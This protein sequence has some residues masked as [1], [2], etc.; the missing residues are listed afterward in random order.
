MSR[1]HPSRPA[2]ALLSATLLLAI[3]APPTGAA[4]AP[5]RPA[6]RD[7]IALGSTVVVSWNDLGMHCMNQNH[8]NMSILPPYNNLFAQ[9]IQR[10][11]ETHP[12]RLLTAGVTVE[13]SVPGNTYSVGKTD[14][15]TYA[16]ALFGV[17]LPPNVG[18]T[19]KGL[20]GS[21]DLSGTAFSAHGIPVSPWPDN[22]LVNE[23]PYQQALVIARDAGGAE[24]AR[25]TPTIPVSTEIHCA[26]PGCHASEQAILNGHERV[27]GFDPNVKP[28]LCAKCHAD[29]ALGTTGNREAN[30]FSLRI[31]DAHKFMD[32]SMSGTAEC[33]RCHP[34]PQTQCL[35]GAMNTLHGQVCQSCHG[36]MAAMARGIENGR[37][38]WVQEPQ[39]G[40]C[41]TAQY[42][43]N[44]GTLFKNSVGHGGIQCEGC[45]NSTHADLPSRQSEDN[46][47][48]VALQGYAGT[49]RECTVCH[50]ITPGGPGPHGTVVASVEQQLLGGAR[51]LAVA[52]N[53][54]RTACAVEVQARAV[55]GGMLMVYDMQG[56]IVR[57]LDTTPAAAGR[58]RATWDGT[59][60]RGGRVPP[61]TYLVA[62]RQGSDRAAARVTVIR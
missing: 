46:A 4:R 52:P 43:E 45:H 22:D 39:C 10:G 44:P 57:K 35:R 53:P 32:Q 50:G 34:G 11:D 59:S 18:L 47:N 3:T 8:V 37:I 29:P 40:S 16:P 25:S 7:A 61:G 62:W 48:N 33:Y 51:A 36:D 20:S 31:H 38:P 19:G 56:R 12:P 42:A 26:G 21:L 58:L 60:H 13:Y 41:H 28:I 1:P 54:M 9:V 14:F 27:T 6:S 23:H 49:L 24:L 17:S 2:V 55:D 5:F 15:W 30:Y